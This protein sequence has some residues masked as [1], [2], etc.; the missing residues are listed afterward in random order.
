MAWAYC[1]N[2]RK[3]NFRPAMI[4]IMKNNCSGISAKL[5]F[6]LKNHNSRNF[7]LKKS[8]KALLTNNLADFRFFKKG[9][10]TFII[11]KNNISKI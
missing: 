7:Y 4:L 11:K 5:F 3:N 9:V 6:L 10:P 1:K 2:T 8:R